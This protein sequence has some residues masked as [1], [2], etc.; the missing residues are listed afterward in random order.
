M[1]VGLTL[2][3]NIFLCACL[4]VFKVG[5]EFLE[6][7]KVE[8]QGNSSSCQHRDDRA[9]NLLGF[10]VKESFGFGL[11]L[12]LRGERYI[13]GLPKQC[14]DVVPLGVIEERPD[15]E[16][17]PAI[18]G[19]RATRRAAW[20][21]C[22]RS[23][24]GYVGQR[25][26][27][28]CQGGQ[29]GASAERSLGSLCWWWDDEWCLIDDGLWMID[30]GWWM[31]VDTWRMMDDKWW[32]MDERSWWMDNRWCMMEDGWWMMDNTW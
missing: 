11:R 14:P 7:A 5:V 27:G 17:V 31:S 13:G 10:C 1:V 21:S 23:P 2:G 20:Q 4:Y 28:L 16:G 25:C 24:T 9:N 22:P 6:N 18:R 19:A 12:N 26:P 8:T 3:D 15:E 30:D 32:L 29:G